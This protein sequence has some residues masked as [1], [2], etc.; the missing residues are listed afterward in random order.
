[1]GVKW[2]VKMVSILTIRT[3][4]SSL[5]VGGL[6]WCLFAFG[7]APARATFIVDPN[8]A[9][10]HLDLDKAFKDTGTVTGHVD[11][12]LVTIG[13]TGNVNTGAGFATITPIKD[14]TLTDLIFTPFS[15]I[16]FS[17]FS[18]RGQLSDGGSVDLAV[19]DQFGS[20]QD[21]TFTPSV[22]KNGDF[23]RLGIV[24]TDNETIKWVEVSG[25]FKE[26][27]QV[28]FVDPPRPDAVP[29]PHTFPLFA[30]GLGL[31]AWVGWRRQRHLRT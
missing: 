28:D 2:G 17:A 1:L 9:G 31:M 8:P 29:E 5:I 4:K 19:M 27:K 18:F 13:T 14:G 7:L 6:S 30:T 24:S 11:G 21:F 10:D 22:D 26:F 15:D 16:V 20:I 25:G 3:L 23:A 12:V